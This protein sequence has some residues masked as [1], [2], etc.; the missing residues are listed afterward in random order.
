LVT[1]KKVRTQKGS[2]KDGRRCVKF[3]ATKNGLRSVTGDDKLQMTVGNRSFKLVIDPPKYV[4]GVSLYE[5]RLHRTL[6]RPARSQ[7]WH[8]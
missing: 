5:V 2:L 3:S 7:G 1:A 8:G 4:R 6:P